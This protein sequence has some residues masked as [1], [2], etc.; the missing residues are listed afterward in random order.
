MGTVNVRDSV[1]FMPDMVK[2]ER[3]APPG[4]VTWAEIDLDAIAAN[5][6]AIKRTVGADTEIIA[7]IKANA[8]GHGEVPVARTVLCHGATRL[9]VHRTI[10]GVRLREAGIRAPIL[11]LGYT[12]PSGIDLVLDYDL[13][14]TAIDHEFV[15]LLSDAADAPVAIHVKVDTGMSR[16]GLFPEEVVGFL[17]EVAAQPNVTVEGL[18]SH[19]ATADEADCTPMLEQW[20]TFRRVLKGVADAGFDIPVRHI[21]NSAGVLSLPAAHLDA[22]RPGILL[23]GQQPSSEC[24]TPFDLRPA[25]TLKS[26][27]VR[28]RT[29]P[30]GSGIGYGRTY[31]TKMP[32]RAALVPIGYGDGYHRLISNR[33]AVLIHGQRA[34]VR[35]RVSMDQIVVDVSGIPDVR[36]GDE[37]VVIGR[38]GDDEISAEDVAQWAETINYEV[39]TALHPQVVRTYRLNG[40]LI[41][42]S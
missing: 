6:R 26:I 19:F 25:L 12:P 10:D 34:P 41:R 9:A 40:R 15:T 28:V 33:G 13:T 27:V 24:R 38:Q 32:M 16:Y 5:T 2:M 30:A 42:E 37:A 35:G 23:Y 14:P 39:L 11:I 7:I 8:Y 31:I 29:L 18:F 22:V 20:Q 4:V 21:C 3:S 1:K 36:L 17:R